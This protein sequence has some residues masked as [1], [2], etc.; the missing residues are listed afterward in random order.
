MPRCANCRGEVASS[1][2]VIDC[3]FCGLEL[4]DDSPGVSS[5]PT[6]DAYQLADEDSPAAILADGLDAQVWGHAGL[7]HVDERAFLGALPILGPISASEIEVALARLSRVV[8][9]EAAGRLLRHHAESS[10]PG[11]SAPRVQLE[12]DA[13]EE[14]H[15]YPL[16]VRVQAAGAK[17]LGVTV[18]LPGVDEVH[19]L[20]S[21]DRATPRGKAM[22]GFAVRTARGSHKAEGS[23][24][25]TVWGAD[26]SQVR[27]YRAR[28]HY[29]VD[30]TRHVV[31]RYEIRNEGVLR[32]NQHLAGAAEDGASRA[33]PAPAAAEDL[34]VV[35]DLAATA[36]AGLEALLSSCNGEA[37]WLEP[38]ATPVHCAVFA[39]RDRS[40]NLHGAVV[41]AAARVALGRHHRQAD[42]PVRSRA[43]AGSLGISRR[44]AQIRW[45]GRL[46]RLFRMGNS[47]VLVDGAALS[48]AAGSF[49][50][51]EV[52]GHEV[53]WLSQPELCWEVRAIEAE[54]VKLPVR[55]EEPVDG[56]PTRLCHV[57]AP[58]GGRLGGG[59]AGS[60][61]PLP[62]GGEPSDGAGLLRSGEGWWLPGVEVDGQEGE[63]GRRPKLLLDGRP[64]RHP[65]LRY[66]LQDGSRMRLPCGTELEYHVGRTTGPPEGGGEIRARISPGGPLEHLRELLGHVVHE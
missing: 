37:A 50:P 32:W 33:R 59:L 36:A 57:I 19:G 48:T 30:S 13:L 49:A 44:A 3:P 34:F 40:L 54:G 6:L 38:A 5:Q 62:P 27:V 66:G 17:R 29:Q 31:T 64:C 35:P 2:G 7:D 4:V 28:F 20:G 21:P 47:E 11:P 55:W 63:R 15:L 8:P 26:P 12:V 43:G 61:L 10:A 46:P 18:E 1:P 14:A 65:G 22:F 56:G 25:I 23:L 39:W 42:L 60:L 45:I 53:T 9:G 16:K 58:E 41:V 24:R 52:H 51:L